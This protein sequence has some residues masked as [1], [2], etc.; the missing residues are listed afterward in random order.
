MSNK[1]TVTIN[2]KV[3]IIGCI[4]EVLLIGALLFTIFYEDPTY[5]YYLAKG[6]DQLKDRQYVT[7]IET[8]DKA[9]DLKPNGVEALIGQ[10]DAHMGLEEYDRAIIKL[11]DAKGIS[12]SNTTIYDKL[13]TA[14]VKNENIN[15]AN[16]VVLEVVDAGLPTNEIKSVKP[17]PTI[18]HEDDEDKNTVTVTIEGSNDESIYYTTN[19]KTP[20]TTDKVYA[21]PITISK[22]GKFKVLALTIE[23]NGLIGFPAKDTFYIYDE[24]SEPE[25]KNYVGTWTDGETTLKITKSDKDKLSFN[26]SLLWV[27]E[28]VKTSSSGT[29]NDGLLNFTYTDNFDNEGTGT[30]NFKNNSIILIMKE[31]SARSATTPGFGYYSALLTK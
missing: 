2:K 25:Y 1:K 29:V 21:K 12:K 7:A 31:T 10:S 27:D 28:V 13:V 4:L 14:Y 15:K 30:I 18:T 17:A 9:L 24:E 16:S 11:E 20:Q 22:P 8:F 5:D 26:I 6:Q 23:E 19:G 3:I